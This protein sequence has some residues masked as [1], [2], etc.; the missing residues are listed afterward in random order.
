MEYS[1][2]RALTE[3]QKQQKQELHKQ[4]YNTRTPNASLIYTW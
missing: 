2:I 4:L 1:R 3:S